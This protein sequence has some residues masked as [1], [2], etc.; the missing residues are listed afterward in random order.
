M[1]KSFSVLKLVLDPVGTWGTQTMHGELC[2][3]MSMHAMP[4][5]KGIEE[6]LG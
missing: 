2:L 4:S 3:R 6:V 1:P 5:K